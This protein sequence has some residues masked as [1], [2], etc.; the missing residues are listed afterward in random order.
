MLD[1]TFLES[2]PTYLCPGCSHCIQQGSLHKSKHQDHA[3]SQ[4]NFKWKDS[5]QTKIQLGTSSTSCP[6]QLFVDPNRFCMPFSADLTLANTHKRVAGHSYLKTAW[7]MHTAHLQVP[8]IFS[9]AGLAL[10]IQASLP[11]G[12][13]Q[14]ALKGHAIFTVRTWSQLPGCIS[15]LEALSRSMHQP[16]TGTDEVCQAVKLTASMMSTESLLHPGSLPDY[17][18][19]AATARKLLHIQTHRPVIGC[20]TDGQTSL[21]PQMGVCANAHKD[22]HSTPNLQLTGHQTASMLTALGDSITAIGLVL[23]QSCNLKGEGTCGSSDTSDLSRS[24]SAATTSLVSSSTGSSAVAYKLG[25]AASEIGGAQGFWHQEQQ[26]VMGI[27]PVRGGL[28]CDSSCYIAPTSHTLHHQLQAIQV[29]SLIDL[30]HYMAN[31]KAGAGCVAPV[32]EGV[33]AWLANVVCTL[34]ASVSTDLAVVSD[35]LLS[36]AAMM[37]LGAQQNMHVV[38]GRYAVTQFHGRLVPGCC[39]LGCTNLDGVSEATL[40]TQ[41]CSGCRRARYCSLKCQKAAWREGGHSF[42]CVA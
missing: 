17:I 42:V 16:G 6:L 35:S 27:A 3:S 19:L 34:R 4:D 13:L 24:C 9:P 18:N 7:M 11:S 2:S 12:S 38:L 36:M 37:H 32:V 25:S 30:C 5:N 22:C 28:A 26:G 21:S 8:G 14:D 39:Y 41:L 29:C 20:V 10:H 31:S 1:S 15:M 33:P 23:Q 40:G